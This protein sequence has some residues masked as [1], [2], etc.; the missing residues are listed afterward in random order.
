MLPQTS[1][2]FHGRDIFAPAAA[3]LEKG[4]KP[5]EFGPEIQDPVKPEF[6]KVKRENGV[7][8]GKILHVDSFGNIITNINKAELK[9]SSIKGQINV[10]MANCQLRLSFKKTY[11]ETKPTEPLSLIGSHGFLEIAL[12]QGSAAKKYQVK[13]GEEISVSPA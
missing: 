10:K 9:Q 6:A 12:N 7:L 2:T 5:V 8:I 1:N 4:V 3:Y 11:A 13:I